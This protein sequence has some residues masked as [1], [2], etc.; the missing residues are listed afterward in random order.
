M[1]RVYIFIFLLLLLCT[2]SFAVDLDAP[3]ERRVPTTRSEIERGAA[4]V[5]NCSTPSLESTINCVLD[6]KERNKQNSTD[7]TP[8]LLGVYFHG[9]SDLAIALKSGSKEQ[10]RHLY[11]SDAIYEKGERWVGIFYKE[12]KQ[13]EDALQI[14]DKTLIG[15][16]HFK[17][18][19]LKKLID[20]Y[21]AK[22]R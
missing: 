2:N 14:D 5:S 22:L 17:Y 18:E 21:D 12:F 8:F 9:W 6:I 15:I 11:Q 1:K 3:V 4:A 13:R 19:P 7:T 16:L 20:D 10:Y